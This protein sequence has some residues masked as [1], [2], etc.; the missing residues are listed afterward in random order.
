MERT[1]TQS[2]RLRERTCR[3]PS[4]TFNVV[5]TISDEDTPSVPGVRRTTNGDQN[6]DT[7]SES[8]TAG[9]LGGL[10]IG[11]D[12]RNTEECDVEKLVGRRERRYGRGKPI[13]EYLLRWK[14]WGP[15]WDM[16]YAEDLLDDA[17]DLTNDPC[18]TIIVLTGDDD[19]L[20]TV[21]DRIHP[22][23]DTSHMSLTGKILRAAEDSV[24]LSRLQCILML[25]TVD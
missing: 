8:L 6:Y 21:D 4:T 7:T 23:N 13:I 16:W 10:P 1:A 17:K 2:R 19:G 25:H 24:Q 20:E 15:E 11:V 22:N 9:K 18:T 5:E 14:G 3:I 12:N